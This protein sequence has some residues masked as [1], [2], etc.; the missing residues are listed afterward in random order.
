MAPFN[1]IDAVYRRQRELFSPQFLNARWLFVP[2]IGRNHWILAA[3]DLKND[4]I[5][6]YNSMPPSTNAMYLEPQVQY[7][8]WVKYFLSWRLGKFRY[9]SYICL[10]EYFSVLSEYLYVYANDRE[11][12]LD[13]CQL[14]L[15]EHTSTKFCRLC[16]FRNTL[17]WLFEPQCSIGLHSG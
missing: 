15:D 8:H 16:H 12:I 5:Q 7:I 2:L 9:N 6:M 3:F 10:G 13:E 11:R 1:D 17:C 4:T 14:V